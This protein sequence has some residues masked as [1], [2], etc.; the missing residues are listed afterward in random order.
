M[1][2]IKQWFETLDEPYKSQAIACTDADRLHI[3][4]ESL[5]SAVSGAFTWGNTEQGHM[6]W[7]SVADGNHT[8]RDNKKQE[9]IAYLKDT[10]I[11]DLRESGSDAT[12]DD[13]ETC[14]RFMEN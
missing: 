9:F 7:S 14:I 11:P 1:K 8:A 4:C 2:T 5:Y 6:Y 12:A 13:F 10:L 3:E